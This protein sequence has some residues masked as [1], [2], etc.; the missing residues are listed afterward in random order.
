MANDKPVS[1]EQVTSE[2]GNN[3]PRGPLGVVFPP[4]RAVLAEARRLAADKKVRIEGLATTVSQDPVLVIEFLKT[5]NALFFAGSKAQI[6]TPRTAIVRLGSDVMIEMIDKCGDRPDYE[7]PEV[8]RWFNIHRG[9]GRRA[10]ILARILSETL[11]KSLGDEIHCATSFLYIGEMIA[12][13]H[14]GETYV[15]LANTNSR[16][17][18]L[19]RLSNDHKFDLTNTALTYLR[20]NGVPESILF[21]LDPEGRA[22]SP[23][24]GIMKA[25]CHAAGEMV[26][27]FDAEKW[28]KFSPGKTLPPKSSLRMLGLSDQA[29]LKI[30]ERTSEFLLSAKLADEKK[31]ATPEV[32]TGITANHPPSQAAELQ[33]EIIQI[34]TSP[35]AQAPTAAPS[36]A[37]KPKTPTP[38]TIKA[39]QKAV[40]AELFSLNEAPKTAPR[41]SPVGTTVT[42][43][44]TPLVSSRGN[45][46]VTDISEMFESVGSSE[47][48]LASLLDML[49]AKGTFEKSALIV[50]S[51]DRQKAIVVAARGPNIGNGQKLSIDDPLSPLAQ[52]FSKV[53]SFG[54]K[55]A[56]C[57]P[58]G[59][60]AFALAP[61]DADHAT[62]VALYADCGTSGS[63]TFEAR[64]VF[65]TVVEILNSKLQQIPGGIPIE[66]E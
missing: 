66:L 5:S 50:V 40:E 56:Q 23:D 54:N 6:E 35:A 17:T 30:Y 59:S 44:P 24:R 28:D 45:Q 42:P 33:S 53:Q 3:R 20:R 43:K 10:A 8:M 37:Q 7:H 41:V 48:L 60:K 39:A 52:C 57:S 21:T 46:V 19:Y 2:N 61:I 63:I 58:W 18:V 9:R 65:R 49:V 16:T 14:F 55:E 25:I 4:D 29:Y 36:A 12:T 64:R 34:L 38:T 1:G 47:E 22:K 11:A 26:E 31:K 62:P 13:A 51:K 32:Q 15:N 27:G